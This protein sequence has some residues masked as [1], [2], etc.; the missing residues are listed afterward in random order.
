MVI[1]KLETNYFVAKEI[2]RFWLL[3]EITRPEI[4]V[5]FANSWWLKITASVYNTASWYFYSNAK[6]ASVQ[7]LDQNWCILNSM[8][9]LDERWAK[10]YKLF[11]WFMPSAV[12]LFKL[13]TNWDPLVLLGTHE[14][15]SMHEHRCVHALL[16]N[17]SLQNNYEN[18]KPNILITSTI[19]KLTRLAMQRKRKKKE[20]L[21]YIQHA[22]SQKIGLSWSSDNKGSQCFHLCYGKLLSEYIKV[23][24]VCAICVHPMEH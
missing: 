20:P 12:P 21:P 15:T 19:I 2:L 8:P 18:N 22:M 5:I 3:E 17:L 10:A 9:I 7:Q 6:F 16:T 14:D 1:T 13:V 24:F 4:L 11:L 23:P